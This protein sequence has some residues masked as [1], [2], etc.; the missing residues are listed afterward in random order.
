MKNLFILAFLSMTAWSCSVA[1]TNEVP[2]SGRPYEIFVIA[3]KPVWNSAVGDTIKS[4][5]GEEVDMLNQSEPL[6]DLFNVEAAQANTTL[7]RHR[8]LIKLRVNDKFTKTELIAKYDTHAKDQLVIDIDSPSLDSMASYI[9]QNRAVLLAFFEKTERDR[10]VAKATKYGDT[11]I[12]GVIKEMFDIEMSI[13][14]GYK[15]RK[16]EDNFLWISNELPRVSMGL[17]IYSFPNF[18]DSTNLL[19]QRNTAVAKIPGPSA[20]SYMTTETMFMPQYTAYNIN[21]RE[22]HELRGFWKVENDFMGGPFV[23]FTTLDTTNNRVIGIDCYVSAPSP[24]DTKR[25][26]IRQLEALVMTVKVDKN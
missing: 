20:G 16:Q 18:T 22:W 13:P 17:V 19:N 12:N 1:P 26:Y 21:G 6:F 10:M 24:R 14:R 3:N 5:F 25:N 7:L 11:N 9:H 15:I 23:N 4:I 8:N 2:S